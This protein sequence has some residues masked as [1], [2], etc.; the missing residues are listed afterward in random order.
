MTHRDAGPKVFGVA[1]E[2]QDPGG[3]LLGCPLKPDDTS[4]R[5]IRH[6]CLVRPCVGL[7][8]YRR[9]PKCQSVMDKVGRLG[10]RFEIEFSQVTLEE[11]PS[12][13]RGVVAPDADL[14]SNKPAVG[15]LA[16]RIEVD[17]PFQRAESSIDP[18]VIE[19]Q[20]GQADVHVESSA[21]EILAH[22]FD[23]EPSALG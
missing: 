21:M 3:Q 10:F 2:S 22:R 5:S 20:L 13:L 6:S 18:V 1:S 12:A 19:M 11:P 23:P 17:R 8:G 9:G 15:L 4:R 7:V 16:D 14:E